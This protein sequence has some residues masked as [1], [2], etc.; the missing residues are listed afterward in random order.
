MDINEYI[1]K[2]ADFLDYRDSDKNTKML[3]EEM[4]E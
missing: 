1:K 3:F 4:E 2:L